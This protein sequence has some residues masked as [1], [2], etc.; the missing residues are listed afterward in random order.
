MI[1][2]APD[3]RRTNT[4]DLT[5]VNV[6]TAT[7]E[8][9]PLDGLVTLER[10][11]SVRAYNRYNRQPS[12]EI[13]A[14][15]VEGVDLGSAIATVEEIAEDMPSAMQISYSGQAESYQETSGVSR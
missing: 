12:V 15:L 9:V 4:A 2:Q 13:S 8:L 6:R 5:G 1:L 10:R 7:G 14:S 11:A 3:A